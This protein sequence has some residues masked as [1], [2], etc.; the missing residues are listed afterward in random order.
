MKIIGLTGSIGMGKSATASLLRGL[1]I[2]VFD[3]D[4]CVHHLLAGKAIP[5]IIALFPQVWDEKNQQIDKVLLSKI[6]F[7]SAENKEKLE[8]I[9]HPLVWEEQQKF[10]AHHRRAARKTIILDVPLL[11]ETGRDRICDHV[12]CVTAPQFIQKN[13]V[14][15]RKGMTIEKYRA[16]LTAQYPDREKRLRSNTVIPTGLGKA[17]TLKKLKK[18]LGF[19]LS[20]GK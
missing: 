19:Q 13:R 16:I 8:S 6:V 5:P 9:L 20:G 2:P 15:S 4:A 7:S 10:I 11:F 12:I 3:S 17:F 18:A 1:K 14:L